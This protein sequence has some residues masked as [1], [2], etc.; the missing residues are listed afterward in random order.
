[1]MPRFVLQVIVFDKKLIM[2]R[3]DYFYKK[4]KIRILPTQLRV[5]KQKIIESIII[6][7]MKIHYNIMIFMLK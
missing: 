6:L 4:V 5:Y 1:M 3:N 7:I 2:R